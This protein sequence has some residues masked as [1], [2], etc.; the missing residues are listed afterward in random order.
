MYFTAIFP[1][2][3]E[4][5]TVCITGADGFKVYSEINNNALLTI[6]FQHMTIV[7]HA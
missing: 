3:Q 2:T 5:E 4:T 6:D 7:V 1:S